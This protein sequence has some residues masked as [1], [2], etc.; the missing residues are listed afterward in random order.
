MTQY[1]ASRAADSFTPNT[2]VTTIHSAQ[3]KASRLP[4]TEPTEFVIPRLDVESSRNASINSQ[5]LTS[6]IAHQSTAKPSAASPLFTRKKNRSDKTVTP[7]F[8]GIAYDSETP[9][10]STRLNTKRGLSQSSSL[11]PHDKQTRETDV[12]PV[13]T[14]KPVPRSSLRK[15]V[16]TIQKQVDKLVDTLNENEDD[17]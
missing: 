15:L 7:E 1:S 10:V 4:S 6:T 12:K 5:L 17:A 16:L 14:H 2:K 13:A 9:A 8:A 11:E 3:H